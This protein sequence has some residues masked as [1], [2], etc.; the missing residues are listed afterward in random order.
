VFVQVMD[1]AAFAGRDAF[2]RQTS[3]LTG[4]CRSNPPAPGVARVRV[5]GDA[6]AASRRKALEMGVPLDT[7]IEEELRRRSAGLRVAWNG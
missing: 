6:A 1:P 7:A 5:P 2:V 4:A 3:H